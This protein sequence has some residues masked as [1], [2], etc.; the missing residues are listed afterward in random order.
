LTITTGIQDLGLENITHRY[1]GVLALN[2]VSLEIEK[3][4]FTAI[5]GPNGAGKSTLA[6]IL[7]GMLRPTNGTVKVK[8]ADR[9]RSYS[10]NGFI[11]L[12]VVL[13]PEGRRLFTT[14]N[15]KENLLLGAYGSGQSKVEMMKSY[16]DVLEFL[17]ELKRHLNKQAG[18]L[19]GGEQQM[20]AVARALMARPTTIILDEPSLG[21]A[22]KMI[23][24]IYEVISSL[25]QREM[26]VI[27]IEQ[28]T[29]YALQH[30]QSMIV[31]EG[32]MIRYHGSVTDAAAKEALQAGYFGTE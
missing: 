7:G 16:E 4:S 10:G 19:S 27:V 3:G 2:H 28:M 22:P 32:G 25:N 20:V 21:L 18:L 11:N 12:G 1:N 31:L 5:L 30:A 14:M 6:L 8:A 24:R 26:T 29:T 15:V 9:S 17:P 13:V 23:E